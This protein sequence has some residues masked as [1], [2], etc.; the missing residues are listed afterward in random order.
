M[1][2]VLNVG[3]HKTGTSSIQSSM[4]GFETKKACYLPMEVANHSAHFCTM[5][6]DDPVTYP[7]HNKNNRSEEYVLE[8]REYYFHKMQS[9]LQNSKHDVM[10]SSGED[11]STL[12]ESELVKMRDWLAQFVDSIHIIGYVRPPYSFM[13]SA[14]QQRISGGGISW[15]PDKLYPI[16]RERFEKFDN[17]FG[18][19]NVELVKFDRAELFE[20]DVVL[21]FAHRAGVD[22]KKSD[23]KTANEAR[24][25]E[26]TSVVAAKRLLGEKL[27]RY[28]RS[29]L[30]NR[31]MI[32][33][34]QGLG[35]S[36]IVLHPDLVQP[37]LDQHAEDLDWISKRLD[38]DF[39]DAAKDSPNA[40]RSNHDLFNISSN[41]LGGVLAAV[42]E[43]AGDEPVKPELV[44]RAVDLLLEVIKSRDTEKRAKR[45]ERQRKKKMSKK[46][47]DA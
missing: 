14:M 22:F 28:H 8:K 1:K 19:E 47:Q 13:A 35:D 27:K 21:D 12:T 45:V 24:S 29:P 4:D 36:K 31:R 37:V 43:A 44:A 6:R 33:M 20:G 7:G 10:V 39:V 41:H 9:C 17:V 34:L 26:T 3:M 15:A 25:L 2:F 30:H 23:I 5:F 38:T 40:I 11:V 42:A 32:E 18:R 16:Y 46:P